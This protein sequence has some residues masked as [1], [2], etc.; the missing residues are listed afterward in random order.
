LPAL[1]Q[2]LKTELITNFPGVD[3]LSV[4]LTRDLEFNV[5]DLVVR[6]E[7]S[8]A[9]QDN[10]SELIIKMPTVFDASSGLNIE[11]VL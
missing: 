2:E 7:F 8:T 10:I 9:N 6:I 4:S 3:F 1:S 5:S 11:N